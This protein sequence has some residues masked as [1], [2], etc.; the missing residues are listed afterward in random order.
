M[1]VLL[2]GSGGREHALARTLARSPSLSKLYC[3]PGN[4]GIASLAECVDIPPREVDRLTQFARDEKIDLVVVGP[5]EPLVLGLTDRCQRADIPVLGPT[6]EAAMLEGSKVFAK[7]ILRRYRIPTATYRVFT[8][9]DDALRYVVGQNVY[10]VVLK[11]DG[12]AAG[13]G[14]LIVEDAD[15]A[16]AGLEKIMVRKSFGE[17]GARRGGR[18]V[19][20]G[21]RGLAARAHRRA[22][23]AAARAGAA[24]SRRRWTATSART[25][26]AWAA[27]RRRRSIRRPTAPSSRRSSSP[28]CTR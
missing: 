17:A 15:S 5:E 26:A 27:T 1:R 14:V 9:F 21:H 8:V 13:K 12:L 16:Y 11:A 6:R 18:G 7:E 3:A 4:A 19:S 24:T 22:H 20:E 25:P 2:I 23:A 10:P 28:S